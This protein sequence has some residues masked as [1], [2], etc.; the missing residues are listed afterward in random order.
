VVPA[1]GGSVDV[2]APNP[3]YPVKLDI[4]YAAHRHPGSLWFRHLRVFGLWFYLIF[5]G[6]GAMFSAGINSYY[7]LF[8]GRYRKRT[9]DTLSRYLTAYYQ[10]AAYRM[11]LV[12]EPPTI[13]Q[14]DYPVRVGLP[15][16]LPV[17]SS[18]LRVLYVGLL[19]LPHMIVAAFYSMIGTLAAWAGWWTALFSGG[20][21]PV[22]AHR[23]NVIALRKGLRLAAYMFLITEE[24]LPGGAA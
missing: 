21:F 23:I 6:W 11:M 9:Y 3:D 17:V 13:G 19:A 5:Q 22:W 24:K 14:T 10:Y 16:D 15:E 8:T 12:E 4:P 18:R 7:I 2:V 20:H 1:P